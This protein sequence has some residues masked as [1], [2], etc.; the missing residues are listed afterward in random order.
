M[1]NIWLPIMA[2]INRCLKSNR[3]NKVFAILGLIALASAFACNDPTTLGSDF[4]G[5]NSLDFV[6]TSDFQISNKTV[7]REPVRTYFS[8]T[9]LINTFLCGELNDPFFGKSRSE[10]FTQLHFNARLDN[11]FDGM[12]LD[13]V[14][15][16]LRYDSFG[17]AGYLDQMVD[18]EV[19]ELDEEM[20][21]ESDY[22]SNATFVTKMNPL[23]QVSFLPAPYD[24]VQIMQDT[25]LLTVTP[26]I[27]I[28]L[29]TAILNN[30][31]GL[32]S[33]FWSKTDSLK[34]ILKGINIRVN[35]QNTML[36]FNLKSGI[37]GVFAYYH[38]TDSIEDTR[39]FQF[40]FSDRAVK[41][42][43]YTH[44]YNPSL[45]GDVLADSLS[46]TSDSITLLQE[47]QGICPKLTITG[48]SKLSG[49]AINHAELELTVYE[50]EMDDTTAFPKV[51]LLTAQ[52]YG[53]TSI[54]NTTDTH[55]SLLF[56]RS[57]FDFYKT[58]FKG[59]CIE[60]EINGDK[61]KVYYAVITTQIQEAASLGLDEI[62][63]YINSYLR[64][65]SPKRV[66]FYGENTDYPIKLHVTYTDI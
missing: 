16:V 62:T 46:G 38:R 36:G 63:V 13:S 34:E 66:L 26:R 1:K 6:K 35:A 55:E 4:L 5:G 17:V 3:L 12:T 60:K 15:L 10:I 9:P 31:K 25:N 7:V 49:A 29:D 65:E 57:G 33:A 23:A 51:F 8:S 53:D 22:R 40:H 24:S 54:V 59:E 50:S 48:L 27:R 44:E 47:M 14:V 64:Q 19:Y 52:E 32:D 61:I 20:D 43:H 45:A 42:P 18:L 30:V 41:S 2:S 37:S 21:S 56:S 58:S 28:P 11:P 39:S